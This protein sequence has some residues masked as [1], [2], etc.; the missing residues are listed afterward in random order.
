MPNKAP[1]NEN[2]SRAMAY[3]KSLRGKS[4]KDIADALGIPPTTIS[5]WNTGRHL[6]DMERLQRLASYL[7]APIEHFFNFSTES[8]PNK[9]LSDLQQRLSTDSELV[10]FLKLFTKLSDEDR[11][12][13][14][15][16]ALKI[17]K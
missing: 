14:V 9:E 2:F 17:H 10:Q 15:T 16:I 3:Y 5:A 11:H 13:L 6:P 4:N 7:D 1:L 8:L 12:L